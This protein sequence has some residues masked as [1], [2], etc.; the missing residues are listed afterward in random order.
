M[1][2]C[3][4]A[5]GST[6]A[7]PDK[8]RGPIRRFA[9]GAQGRFGALRVLHR[10]GTRRPT[11]IRKARPSPSSPEA[12][13]V[14]ETSPHP[15]GA[16]APRVASPAQSGRHAIFGQPSHGWG[17][18]T[19]R[20]TREIGRLT[21]VAV[22]ASEHSVCCTGARGPSLA[23]ARPNQRACQAEGMQSFSKGRYI[24]APVLDK[25]FDGRTAVRP[26]A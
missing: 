15:V 12:G 13:R 23:V 11:I 26:P 9:V 18:Q 25:S 16:N 2:E 19:R 8:R 3:A 17:A 6:A 5:R 14:N 1:P 10:S 24:L 21:L 4:S 7:S 22:H 20:L